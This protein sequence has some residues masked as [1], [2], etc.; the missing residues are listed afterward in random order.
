MNNSTIDRQN[1]NISSNEALNKFYSVGESISCRRSHV[2]SPPL[3]KAIPFTKSHSE[4]IN[5][6]FIDLANQS[7]TCKFTYNLSE[8]SLLP[9]TLRLSELLQ[10]AIHKKNLEDYARNRN[11]SRAKIEEYFALKPSARKQLR[12]KYTAYIKSAKDIVFNIVEF[13]NA[14]NITDAYDGAVDLLAECDE[15]VLTYAIEVAREKHISNK[16]LEIAQSWEQNWEILI[17]AVSCAIK[18]EP[19]KKMSLLLPLC[20]SKNK[21]SILIKLALID[22]IVDLDIDQELIMVMLQIFKSERESDNFIR[23]YAIEQAEE[24]L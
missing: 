15:D 24:C 21:L 8:S 1:Q 3:R 16:N 12:E 4:D 17:K 18:I 11:I 19:Y 2:D 22:A 5:L 14:R 6:Q 20:D 13:G 10:S 23:N 7:S 9:F